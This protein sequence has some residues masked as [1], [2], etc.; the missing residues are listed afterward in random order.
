MM[1]INFL[2]CRLLLVEYLLL[3]QTLS[4]IIARSV[5]FMTNCLFLH[6]ILTTFCYYVLCADFD[7]PILQSSSCS[8]ALNNFVFFGDNRFLPK[9]SVSP[10]SPS[11]FLL[12]KIIHPGFHPLLCVCVCGVGV[13]HKLVPCLLV[14][15]VTSGRGT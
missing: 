12:T 2:L 9:L 1:H 6:D 14:E 4:I 3:V 7:L 13:W 15:S 5:I 10:P 11:L 8:L